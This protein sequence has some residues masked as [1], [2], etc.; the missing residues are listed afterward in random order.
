[1]IDL[2]C[3]TDGA[4]GASPLGTPV[5]DANG[6]LYGTAAQG[7]G[8]RNFGESG[9]GTVWEITG[10]VRL[11]EQRRKFVNESSP[12]RLLIRLNDRF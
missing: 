4:D 11:L 5:L 10:E 6:N 12:H 1:M 8:T 3:F 9:C 7:A 2:Y